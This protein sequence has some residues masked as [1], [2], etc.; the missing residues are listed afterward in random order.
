MNFLN[1]LFENKKINLFRTLDTNKTIN[2][3][4]ILRKKDGE[5]ESDD[6]EEY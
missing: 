4:V 2:E 3:K 6:E 5:N 1:K